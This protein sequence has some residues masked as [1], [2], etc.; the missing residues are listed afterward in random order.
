MTNEQAEI[1]LKSLPNLSWFSRDLKLCHQ[2]P[3]AGAHMAQILHSRH[4]V[5]QG[6]TQAFQLHTHTHTLQN[7]P[8]SSHFEKNLKGETFFLVVFFR[9][10]YN[11]TSFH[12]H[13]WKHDTGQDQIKARPYDLADCSS[14]GSSFFGVA[15]LHLANKSL[16]DIQYSGYKMFMHHY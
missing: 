1:S 6:D 13:V 12:P 10:C 2:K 4:T 5:A 14:S 3:A 11:K 8:F 15:I 7:F 9:V 16:K